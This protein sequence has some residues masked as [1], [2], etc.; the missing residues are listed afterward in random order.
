M[1]GRPMGLARLALLALIGIAAL[2]N[3]PQSQ[4]QNRAGHTMESTDQQMTEKLAD[5][6]KRRDPDVLYQALES[7]EAA[8]AA[9]PV[10]DVAARKLAVSRRLQFFGALDRFIDPA[11]NEQN[12]PPQGVPPPAG[13]NGMVYS[14][15]E[16]DPEKI[17][18]P[19][20]RTKYVQALKD[21]KAAQQRYSAQLQLRR[22][23]DRAMLLFGR[24]INDK[25]TASE[26]DRQE[27]EQ[28]LAASPVSGARKEALRALVSKPR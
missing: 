26:R 20:V 13:W 25:F 5:F 3:S 11:W 19:E 28:L 21:N 23:Q 7:I 24:F 27:F 4:R 18:D 2:S 16:V 22:I 12:V 9:V 10:G 17:S 14:S 8:E 6:E 15:G 1:I